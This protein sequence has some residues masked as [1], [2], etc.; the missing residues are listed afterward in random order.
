M[1]TARPPERQILNGWKEIA[2]FLGR[3]IRTVQRWENKHGMPVHRP[4]GK[5]RTAVLAFSD[6]LAQWLDH[7]ALKEKVY[8][9]PTLVVI[10]APHPHQLSDRKLALEMAKFNVLTAFSA[11]EALATA[12]RLDVDGFVME[13]GAVPDMASTD[14]CDE[15]KE[16]YPEKPIVV[17]AP[18]GT[19][20][21]PNADH[22]LKTNDPQELVQTALR[23][24]GTPRVA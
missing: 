14:L 12:Q 10:D 20:L 9:R 15:L 22:I 17:L 4:A 23:L 16:L 19:K 1:K 13:S 6:E 7:S 18:D 24:F 2:I 21:P 8:I 3:G 11:T 5:D